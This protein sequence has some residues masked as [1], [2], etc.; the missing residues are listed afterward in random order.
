MLV[1]ELPRSGFVVSH[2]SLMATARFSP[3]LFLVNMMADRGPHC[4][5]GHSRA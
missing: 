3:D 2:R 4:L 5:S 1:D